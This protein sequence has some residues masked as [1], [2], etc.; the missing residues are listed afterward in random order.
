MTPHKNKQQTLSLI[1]IELTFV[2]PYL[3]II[4]FSLV[5][6]NIRSQKSLSLIVKSRNSMGPTN[7]TNV[8]FGTPV[9]AQL[10]AILLKYFLENSRHLVL[11]IITSLDGVLCSR[12]CN[13]G[14][15]L[16][17]I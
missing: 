6:H 7:M 11:E 2:T 8:T 4:L 12:K 3:G 14:V 17:L 13:T 15:N 9:C 1:Y 10:I 5:A 16:D